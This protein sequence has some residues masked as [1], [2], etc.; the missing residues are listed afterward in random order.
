MTIFTIYLCII[1]ILMKIYLDVCC[2]NR[3]FDD[4]SQDRIRMESEAVLII[5]GHLEARDWEWIGSEIIDFE[6]DQT[7]DN[8][9]RRRAHLI[10][11]RSHKK[12]VLTEEIKLR[13]SYLHK[14]GFPAIDALHIACAESEKTDIFLTTDDRLLNLVT[15]VKSDLQVRLKNPLVWI[16]EVLKK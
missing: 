16:K 9:R 6:I 10:A 15:T 13:A 11:D 3:P 12:V 7:P 14:I 5:I 1:A 8:E 4:Q 2:L